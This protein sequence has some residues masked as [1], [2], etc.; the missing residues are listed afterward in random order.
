MAFLADVPKYGFGTAFSIGSGEGQTSA[1]CLKELVEQAIK[2]GCRHF[3]CAPLYGTQPIVGAAIKQQMAANSIARSE[4]FITSKLPVNM[5]RQDKIE[6]SFRSTLAE[7][8]VSYLD[9]YLIHAPFATKYVA[10]D[11]IYPRDAE[12]NLLLDEQEDLLECAWRKLIELKQRGY[13]RYIGASNINIRQLDRLLKVGQVDVVQ[14][15]YHLYH[16]DREFFDYCEEVDVHYEAYAAFGCPP[17]AKLDNRPTFM[18]DPVVGRIA[19]ENN[20]NRA[21]VIMQWLHQQPLSYIIRTDNISQLEENIK[22]TSK[23]TL[24]INDMIDLDS[25]NQNAR[26]YRYDDSHNGIARHIEYPFKKTY[27]GSAGQSPQPLSEHKETPAVVKH[28][29]VTAVSTNNHD[30]QTSKD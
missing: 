2:L 9:L 11:D 27:H 28:Q 7:L 26:L 10:D 3:D 15:E 14:N 20:L 25:L 17:K 4:I 5:M 21:Q 16:Q 13:V 23:I 22:A 29:E 8:D 6:K 24:S 18:S 30:G 19:D 1:E 12:G